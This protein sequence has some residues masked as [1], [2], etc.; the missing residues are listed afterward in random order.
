[1]CYHQSN[2][3]I[4]VLILRC[5]SSSIFSKCLTQH[6]SVILRNPSIGRKASIRLMNSAVNE[7]RSWTGYT[8]NAKEPK[9]A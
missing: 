5:D 8:L 4:S 2:E 9:H 7:S 6:P 3:I 1:M